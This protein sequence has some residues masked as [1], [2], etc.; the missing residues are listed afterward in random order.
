MGFF[1]SIFSAK[2]PI[3][4]ATVRYEEPS[5]WDRFMASK[6]GG[7]LPTPER[8]SAIRDARLGQLQAQEAAPVAKMLSRFAAEGNDADP[9]FTGSEWIRGMATTPALGGTM[10]EQDYDA[11][12][13]GAVPGFKKGATPLTEY[14]AN[15]IAAKM[16]QDAEQNAQTKGTVARVFDNRA[17]PTDLATVAMNKDL[18]GGVENTTQATDRQFKQGETVRGN[19]ANNALNKFIADYPLQPT[20]ES[21]NS[22]VEGVRRI[23]GI[24]PKTIDATLA[25]IAKRNQRPAGKPLELYANSGNATTRGSVRADMFGNP[26]PETKVT[27]TNHAP[28]PGT[29]DK[30]DRRQ[31]QKDFQ[32]DLTYKR[33]LERAV[34]TGGKG[35][36]MIDGIPTSFDGS[37][38]SLNSLKG[39]LSDQDKTMR[40]LYPEEMA[41]RNP[42]RKGDFQGDASKQVAFDN[43]RQPIPA[44]FARESTSIPGYWQDKNGIWWDAK[45]KRP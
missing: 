8:F 28:Q 35:M 15:P 22:L 10:S 41:K 30:E 38:E 4:L 44:S 13:T 6:F 1:D 11:M 45:T 5:L 7:D 18:A 20:V 40:E 12:R 29:G 14:T 26:I 17:T 2:T 32:N 16:L 31:R 21:W 25:D 3:E 42:K 43:K 33:S 39:M 36:I 27:A 23:P 19:T 37:V 34:A 24:D 9:N